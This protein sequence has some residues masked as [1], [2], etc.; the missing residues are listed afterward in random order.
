MISFKTLRVF[1]GV[2]RY[3]SFLAASE[4][5]SLTAAA[6]GLQMKTLEDELGFTVFDRTGRSVTLNHRGHLFAKKAEAMVNL[7]EEAKYD[8]DARELSGSMRISSISTSMHLLVRAIITM[9]KSHPNITVESGISY[10]GSLKRRVVE[11][12]VDGA[13]TVKSPHET[14]EDVLWTPLYKEPLAFI[15]SKRHHEGGEI[16]KILEKEIFFQ[17]AI[18][19]NTGVLVDDI[20]RRNHIRAHQS[21]QID[22]VRVIIDLVRDGLGVTILPLSQGFDF[23]AYPDLE[24][25]FFDG[26]HAYRTIGFI[27]NKSKSF[28]TSILRSQLLSHL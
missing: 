25:R 22:A 18:N 11:G 6:V 21:I 1:L 8:Q 27:E 12:D 14:M 23:G 3:G 16:G 19:S 10:S 13:L 15:Y 5:V 28:L 4:H 20:M 26:P 7:F 9:R 2:A 24:V 17:S